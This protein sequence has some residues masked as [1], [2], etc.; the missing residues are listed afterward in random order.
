MPSSL[1]AQIIRSAISPRL[2]TRT[3]LNIRRSNLER[4]SASLSPLGSRCWPEIEQRLAELHRLA[5][6][7]MALQHFA[8]EL[9]F[10]LVHELHG[11]NNA[12][13][14]PH[15]DTVP[16]IH[17]WRR[18]LTGSGIKRTDHGRSDNDNIF[19][20][21]SRCASWR[22]YGGSGG[23]TGTRCPRWTG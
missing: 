19:T 10:N 13:N 12:E 17:K 16:D 4:R 11:F 7:H 8:I 1:Q 2:A 5:V 21:S 22:C 15:P 23:K 6:L 9:R 18:V 3:F 20:G 14:L